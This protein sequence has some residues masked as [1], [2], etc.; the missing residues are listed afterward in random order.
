MLVAPCKSIFIPSMEKICWWTDACIS[1][2]FHAF[3]HVISSFPF[4]FSSE[5]PSS[6]WD[7][8]DPHVSCSRTTHSWAK[9]FLSALCL[10]YCH[11]YHTLFPLLVCWSTNLLLNLQP[12]I[13]RQTHLSPGG[14]QS[15][16]V[17]NLSIDGRKTRCIIFCANSNSYIITKK[18]TVL[19]LTL[20]SFFSSKQIRD[21][22]MAIT[23]MFES[24][25]N[26]D[27]RSWFQVLVVA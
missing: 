3:N 12:L 26:W 9:L 7:C 5:V 22:K 13:A 10:I 25:S 24:H 23:W 4:D 2:T 1:C 6:R 21:I 17:D 27:A 19:L 18:L 15:R 20:P 11:F 14:R 16:V 8:L